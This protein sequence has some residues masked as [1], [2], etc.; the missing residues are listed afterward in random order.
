MLIHLLPRRLSTVGG[1][2]ALSAA[3]PPVVEAHTG[4]W[5]HCRET[6]VG[7]AYVLVRERRICI[8]AARAR[9][10]MVILDRA[11]CNEVA[12]EMCVKASWPAMLHLT[13]QRHSAS[14]RNKTK[15]YPPLV[16]ARSNDGQ[17]HSGG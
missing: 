13:R 8:P 17:T 11:P 4:N 16:A 5:I 7:L 14:R 2:E 9:E 15:T 10:L 3:V 1:A 12:S 6:L